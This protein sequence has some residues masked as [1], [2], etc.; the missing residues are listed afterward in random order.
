M[1]PFRQ[2]LPDRSDTQSISRYDICLSKKDI[3][4]HYHQQIELIYV[5]SG[6]AKALVG[7]SF[8]EI[9]AGAFLILGED[10]PHDLTVESEGDK[11]DLIVLHFSSCIVPSLPEFERLQSVIE[12]SQFG[13]Y[14][15]NIEASVA[16]KLL[17]TRELVGSSLFIC[18]LDALN[19]FCFSESYKEMV[20]LSSVRLTHSPLDK[21]SYDRLNRVL[22]YIHTNKANSISITQIAE[23]SNM[24]S[25]A[26]C[27]WFK[28]SMSI[29]FLTYLNNI[30]VDEACRLLLNT[31]RQIAVI[32]I[33]VG[34]DSLS[35]FN[36]NFT[37]LKSTS[38][39]QYRKTLRQIS[40]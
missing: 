5:V 30:R 9:V 10:L 40:Q 12:K 8:R 32:A 22:T 25:T 21:K 38:P 27:R 36:R 4:W 3:F 11:C 16:A 17:S 6:G 39:S 18:V 15:S 34:F 37:K 28:R 26:F 31:D 1:R 35:S 20:L 14:S 13:V 7:D 19:E 23:H 2:Q 24:T 33:D 29:S